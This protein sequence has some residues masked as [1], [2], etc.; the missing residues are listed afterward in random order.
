M[1]RRLVMLRARIGAVSQQPLVA[2]SPEEWACVGL[3]P[4]ALA[5]FASKGLPSEA[6]LHDAVDTLHYVAERCVLFARALGI[7]HGIWAENENTLRAAFLIRRA[8]REAT[9]LPSARSFFLIMFQNEEDV[10]THLVDDALRAD[11]RAAVATILAHDPSSG[12]QQQFQ[13]VTTIL[14]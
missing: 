11:L 7:P 10:R 13:A 14:R 1:E 4:D 6:S 3:T 5:A 8:A 9:A 12:A 2:C